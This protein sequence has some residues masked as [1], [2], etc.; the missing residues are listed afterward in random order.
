MDTSKGHNAALEDALRRATPQVPPQFAFQPQYLAQPQYPLQ[1][2]YA[3]QAQYASQIP[4]PQPGQYLQYPQY[5]PQLQYPSP[6]APSPYHYQP[7]MVP[8]PAAPEVAG[9]QQPRSPAYSAVSPR[10]ASPPYRPAESPKVAKTS[11]ESRLPTRKAK[12]S[13][14]TYRR[15]QN[16]SRNVSK[17]RPSFY[18]TDVSESEQEPHDVESEIDEKEINGRGRGEEKGRSNQQN[19]APVSDD[20]APARTSSETIG[21]GISR[22]KGVNSVKM[23]KIKSKDAT[24]GA[25]EDYLSDTRPKGSK[26]RIAP[27]SNGVVEAKKE[28]VALSDDDVVPEKQKLIYTVINRWNDDKSKWED[29]EQNFE[30]KKSTDQHKWMATFRRHMDADNERKI[31]FEEI[32]VHAHALTDLLVNTSKHWHDRVNESDRTIAVRTP[33]T[34]F[35]WHWDAHVEACKPKKGDKAEL[36]SARHVLKALMQLLEDSFAL[37]SYF[38]ERDMLKSSKK[39]RYKY[40]WTLFADG[41]R[42]YARSYQNELQMFEVKDCSDNKT[43][44]F[45]VTCC[46]FDWDGT[47]FLTYNYDFYIKEFTGEKTIASLEIFPIEYYGEFH[48]ASVD[49]K[50]QA[51]LLERGKR[52]ID[53]CSQEHTTFQ[54]EYEGS[55]LVTPSAL[56]RLASRV[57]TEDSS[58]AFSDPRDSFYE[59]NDA[60][61]TSIDIVGKQSRVIIDNL[62]F[63]KSERN[64]MKHNGMPP[65]GRRVPYF[66][67]DCVCTIC[68]ES[69][70]QQWRPENSSEFAESED[71]L[72]FLPPRLL[73]YALK[74]KVWGQFLVNRLKRVD[75]SAT[76]DHAVA[77]NKE[78]QLEEQSKKVLMAFVQHHKVPSVRRGRVD[79][80][81]PKTFDIIE[82]KGQ[83]L[84]IML[85]GPPGVGKTLTAE[86]IALA[87]GRPLLSVSVAEIGVAA[88]EAERNLTDFF[89]DAARWEAVLLMDE[90]DVFVEERLKGDLSRNALVSVLLRCLEYYDGIIILTTNRVRS[91][92]AAVQSRIQLA[93]Q[94]HDLSTEQRLAIY[95]NRLEWVPPDEIE[96]LPEL[97]ESLRTSALV[98]SYNQAN[99]RQIRN[100]VTYARALAKSENSKLTLQHLI[101][102]DDTTKV[103]MN[104]MSDLVSIQRAKSEAR[105]DK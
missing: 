32:V 71:R 82:G 101:S 63:L 60:E 3:S 74:E 50:L 25:D 27:A 105:Y 65:L 31:E 40:L 54:C 49:K 52:Y 48:G 5:P 68:R 14:G 87:T 42:V 23:E 45:R 7:P 91:I 94:Y 37:R 10:V 55:S 77:F 72:R 4:Y 81:D 79:G 1:P 103:F 104:N 35:I 61:V 57:R 43:S 18:R 98:K 76:G 29:V 69:P 66:E 47:N 56:H 86:T 96:N 88:K 53:L 100:I 22:L 84:V 17:R 51:D 28:K 26:G 97:I 58:S 89:V 39:I 62:S 6:L 92:D 102:V 75:T 38:R 99:G 11:T 2:Q 33:F 73:G 80:I 46:A 85:H 24:S 64:T 41:C 15:P 34:P 36:T 12:V 44:R 83:G 19:G 13:T 20:E 70:L 30:K 21:I 78:L 8:A 90:A 67:P 95:K 59:T 16:N 9:V 93:I